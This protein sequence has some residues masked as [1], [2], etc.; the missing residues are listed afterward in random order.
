MLLVKAPAVASVSR[1]LQVSA[2][3]PHEVKTSENCLWGSSIFR[4]AR[5]VQPLVESFQEFQIVA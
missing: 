3:V 2:G 1:E 5:S 4:I